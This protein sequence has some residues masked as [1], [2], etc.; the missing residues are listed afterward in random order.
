MLA[1]IILCHIQLNPAYV[2]SCSQ[3]GLVWS[4]YVKAYAVNKFSSINNVFYT[5]MG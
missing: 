3:L 1:Q 2:A 5:Y 4:G